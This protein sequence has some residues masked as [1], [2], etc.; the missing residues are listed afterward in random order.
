MSYVRTPNAILSYSILSYAICYAMLCH[1]ML[2][3]AMTYYAL[4]L[5][6][7][8]TVTLTFTFTFA[9]ALTLVS[10]RFCFI[11]GYFFYIRFAFLRI[12]T[13]LGIRLSSVATPLSPTMAFATLV[14]DEDVLGHQPT[15]PLVAENCDL[16]V[17]AGHV[18][19]LS[20]LSPDA[21]RILLSASTLFPDPRSLG[22]ARAV[23]AYQRKEYC[24]LIARQLKVGKVGLR[25]RVIAG[26]STFVVGKRSGKL[27]EVW[28]GSR[29][30]TAALRPPRPPSRSSSRRPNLS[31]PNPGRRPRRSAQPPPLTPTS[32]PSCGKSC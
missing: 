8:L 3:C 15:L 29:L 13:Q 21:R 19:A 14:K 24:K 10:F 25:R 12:I 32:W 20:K 26:A 23:P 18:D 5:T 31:S 16:P 11:T 28:N 27:R 17:S 30:S 4:T 9:L 1:A 7:T 6:L 2:C 22:R